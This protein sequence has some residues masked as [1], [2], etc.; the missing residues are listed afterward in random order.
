MK[1]TGQEKNVLL[2]K[3]LVSAAQGD[4]EAL[5]RTI[6]AIEAKLGW[7]LFN[8]VKM[9]IKDEDLAYDVTQDIY[10]EIYR[11]VK[12]YDPTKGSV[13][14][15]LFSIARNVVLRWTVGP[16]QWGAVKEQRDE[17]TSEGSI[18]DKQPAVLDNLTNEEIYDFVQKALREAPLK[19]IERDVIYSLYWLDLT[20][21]ETAKLVGL[22]T[23]QN[24]T[25][26]RN[27]A[28]NTLHRWFLSEGINAD[29][30]I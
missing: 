14:A 29:D 8:Y 13:K 28:L 11:A 4:T 27:N 12:K 22:N 15:W 16:K 30:L 2:Q 3:L 24:V 7:Q 20:Y 5:N 17:N 1:Q 6:V 23:R 21:E 25:Y 26:H 18:P 10:V 9:K 19:P